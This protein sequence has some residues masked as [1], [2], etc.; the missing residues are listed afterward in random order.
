MAPSIYIVDAAL[1]PE[2]LAQHHAL[3][4][5]A[6]VWPRAVFCDRSGLSGPVPVDGW[7][8]I[9][10]PDLSRSAD[11]VLPGII[12]SPRMGSG[13]L[14]GDIPLPGDL[15]Q[16]GVARSL[17]ENVSRPGRRP[18]GRP[19]RQAGNEAVEDRID[20]LA[21][22]GGAGRIRN[23]LS[24]LDVIAGYY[25]PRVVEVVRRRLAAVLGTV[26]GDVLTSTRLKARLAGQPYDEHRIQLVTGLV[27]TLEH[28]AP[29]A[30][31]SLGPALRWQWLP[32]FEAYFSNFI[33]GTEFGVDEARRIAVEG[34]VPV[35]RPADAHDISA[36]YRLVSDP[37]LQSKTP[38]TADELLDT[39]R[40][41]HAVLMA[42]RPDKRPGQFKVVPNYAGGYQ[43]VTPDLLEGTLRRG[44]A[45]LD[46][47]TDPFQRATAMMFLLTECHPFDDGNGRLGRVL[48]NAEL[49]AGGQVR[50][51]IPT[52]YRNNYL[53]ALTGLSNQAGSGQSL[54]SVLH[55]A[56][57]WTARI[58]WSSFETAKELLTSSNAFLDPGLAEITGQRLVFPP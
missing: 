48:S 16:A 23:V 58:D 54:I 37:T 53:A 18:V 26:S 27:E 4:I 11:L 39:L 51:V 17:V 38:K 43:F 46:K 40:E 41:Y 15:F 9:C 44:F 50:I 57:R 24:E 29:A 30:I 33:E 7:L 47:L 2:A 22:T 49:S 8:F 20:E 31:P 13:R 52:V 5:I 34:F 45:T 10:Q 42:A 35:E 28:T 14:P 56:Q 55:F 12:I 1:P 3:A 6:A 19:S 21:R 32:F 25:D 36:T